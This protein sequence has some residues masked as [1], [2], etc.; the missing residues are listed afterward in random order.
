M[1]EKKELRT[2]PCGELNGNYISWQ[3]LARYVSLVYSSSGN[4]A[5][6]AGVK[7]KTPA[8]SEL[9]LNQKVNLNRDGVPGESIPSS[10]W[11]C[12]QI[13][14]TLCNECPCEHMVV[15]GCHV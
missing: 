10:L 8:A 7:L 9:S 11:S 4:A 2:Y 1:H 14:S 5:S 13:S 15:G 12:S 3:C 6:F